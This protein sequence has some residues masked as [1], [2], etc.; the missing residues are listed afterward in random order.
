M[1]HNSKDNKIIIRWILLLAWMIFIFY[2]SSKSGDESLAQSSY[3]YN[4]IRSIGISLDGHFAEFSMII[5]RK[6]AHFLEYMVLYMLSISLISKYVKSKMVYIYPLVIVLLYACGDEFHQ[7]FVLGRAG[8]ITDV[9]IDTLG[10]IFGFVIIYTK[11][12]ILGYIN[13]RD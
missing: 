12:N 5:I 6:G 9:C 4:I 8:R 1:K 7:L 13:K 2:M 11:N 10:G 3:I